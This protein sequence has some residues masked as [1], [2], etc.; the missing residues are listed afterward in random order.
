MSQIY[1]PPL[2]GNR[3]NDILYGVMNVPP[4]TIIVVRQGRLE[5]RLDRVTD[6]QEIKKILQ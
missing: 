1:Y 4:V 2:F 3:L 5:S 6:L